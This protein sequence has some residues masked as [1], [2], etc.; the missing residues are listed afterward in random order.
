MR[1]TKFFY[2]LTLFSAVHPAFGQSTYKLQPGDAIEIWM[3]QYSDLTRQV[4]LAPDGWIS[5]PLAGAMHAEGMTLE[6][7]QTSLAQRLQPFFNDAVGLNVSLVP[8]EQ[9]LPSI[10]V[11]GDVDTPGL[12]PFR[13]GMTVL[14][15][16]S[17][18]GG[19]YRSSLTASDRDRSLEVE[20]LIANGE[21]RLNEL[22]I[23]IARLNAQIAGQPEFAI[24]ASVDALAVTGFVTREQALLT[25]QSNNIR[26][27]Q[28]SL[29]RLIKINEDSIAATNEQIASIQRRITLAQERLTS[30]STLVERGVMQ[31][32]QVRDIE[33]GIIDMESS[34]SQLRSSL[35]TQ[36]A[37]ILTEQSRVNTLIQEF[38]VGLVT[39][40]S[41]AEGE[42]EDL[43][44]DLA[45]HRNTLELY[46]PG[47][48]GVTTL[49]YEIIRKDDGG[50]LDV[51]A[52]EQT[53][54]LPGDLVRVT[55]STLSA[56]PTTPDPEPQPA[57]DAASGM[58]PP[59]Q[60]ALSMLG[61]GPSHGE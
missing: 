61:T 8:N 50:S 44:S 26:S 55:R 49:R 15:A 30:A 59:A 51:D 48:V 40:L 47:A 35:A 1:A 3:A 36:Q 31:A 6:A 41:A 9:H 53:T 19:L 33:V 58:T 45:N 2:L 21:K 23:M 12:Y 20:S 42:R 11:A 5:L 52:T 60:G 25:M 4:T 46:E 54:I 28:D 43:Q 13:P 14:H 56:E 34:L 18:A 16:I 27:Q 29:D 10:F 39:Q 22:D 38:Q 7:L 32:S 17:V 57:P 24:P 37:S